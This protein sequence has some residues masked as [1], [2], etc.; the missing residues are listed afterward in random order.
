M[1]WKETCVMEE[2]EKFCREVFAQNLT[3]S[4]ICHRFGVSRP[5][6][7]KWIE[8]FEESGRSGL[9]DH[10]RARLTQAHEVADEM[11]QQLVNLRVKHPT[12][13][14]KKLVAWMLLRGVENVPA[15]STVGEILKRHGLVAA[16]KRRHHASQTGPLLPFG[17]IVEPNELWCA[18]FKGWFLTGDG[19]RCDPLTISDTSSRLLL[20][21]QVTQKTNTDHVMAVFDAAFREFGLPARIR[22]DNGAPFASV[23]LL[24]LSRLNVWWLKLGILSERIKP[25]HPEQNGRHERMHQ[26]LKRE[27]ASP[28]QA[29]LRSQQKAFDRFV[30]CYNE[31]RPHEAL[32]QQPPSKFYTPSPRRY[33]GYAKPFDYPNHMQVRRVRRAG[34]VKWRYHRIQLTSALIGERVG[35]EEVA[36]GVWV[37]WAGPIRL[38]WIDERTLAQAPKGPYRFAPLRPGMWK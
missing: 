13:G 10:S 20:R 1:S 8:R 12:W 5:T 37:I 25:G 32:G 24:G 3:F 17:D 31:E 6:G 16:R 7:Y 14:P 27:T 4:E 35:I 2:R 30:H 23:G 33:R 11:V 29:N 28:P 36:D 21:C 26:T 18:D 38:G 9:S 22:T 34:E 19:C 15:P